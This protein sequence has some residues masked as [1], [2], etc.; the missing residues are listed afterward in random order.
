M[1]HGDEYFDAF[2][3]AAQKSVELGL[4]RGV[5]DR[6]PEMGRAI[7]AFGLVGRM[8]NSMLYEST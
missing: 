1:H 4:I 6:Q 7:D 5:P 8:I 3:H 2:K